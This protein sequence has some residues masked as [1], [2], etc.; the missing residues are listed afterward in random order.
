ML[1]KTRLIKDFSYPITNDPNLIS[2]LYKKREFY[3][4]RVPRRNKLTEYEDIQKYREANC[5]AGEIDPREQQIIIPNYIN[6]NT[7]YKG[8]LLFHG[9]GSG[10]TMTAIRVAEQFK[11]QVKKYSTKIFVLV[12]GATTRENFK[13]ELLEKT[14]NTYFKNKEELAQ[15]TK[16]EI[17]VEENNA[18]YNA[19]SYYRILSYKTFH[20]KVLGEKIVEKKLIGNSKLK[21]SYRKNESGEVE[22]E[23]VIDKIMNMNNSILIVDEA[24]NLSG[25]EYGDALKKII[26]NSE[27]L[28]VILLTATPMINL[29]DEII[30]LLNFIR[31]ENDLIQRDKVFMGDKNYRMKLKP[32]GM[33]YLKNMAKGYIS[34]YRGSIPYTFADRVEHGVIPD[35]MLFTPL[36]QCK[37]HEFQYNAYIKTKDNVED[38]LDK[39]SIASANFVFPGMNKERTELI[40]CY[41]T[42]GINNVLLQ[43]SSDGKKLRSLINKQLFQ[44]KLTKDEEDNFIL[45]NDKKNIKGLILD[46]KYL[47][48]FSIKFYTIISK[49][50]KLVDKQE[51]CATAFIYSNL[52]KAGGIELFAESLIQNG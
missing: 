21:S 12:P 25:N 47:K 27:N 7:P 52:V 42:E 19:L 5:K 26:K 18:L 35:G 43:L 13:S 17:N 46:L 48:Y 11:E 49:L 36:I 50:N 34:Y 1:K 32:G 39:T 24:H 2:K 51:G 41:S 40:G 3:Y 15:M 20:K 30:D 8:V 22:R 44:G 16:Q 6:P 23:V 10:K 45:E 37:M 28:R 31:P 14:G 9:V 38:T 33:E 29:A 4:N